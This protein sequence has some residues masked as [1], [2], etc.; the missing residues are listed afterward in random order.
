L[1]FWLSVLIS[2]WVTAYKIDGRN[3]I[4]YTID[5]RRV[6]KRVA[7][8][9]IKVKWTDVEN[10]IESIAKDDDEGEKNKSE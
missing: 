6:K 7:G 1:L 5:R 9:R 10:L 4:N 3:I 2:Y 8:Q